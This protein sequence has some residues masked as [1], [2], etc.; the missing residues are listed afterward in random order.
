[1]TI[2][3]RKIKKK[4]RK[5]KALKKY[6]PEHFLNRELSWLEFNSRVLNE[7]KT[8]STPLLER[9]RFLSIYT[10][11][12]DE[13]VMKRVG[14]LKAHLDS[15]YKSY[16]LDGLFPD[17]QLE[18]IREKIL[19]DNEQLEKTFKEIKNELKKHEI[20]LSHWSDLTTK[21][22]EYCHQYFEKELYPI[23]TPLSVDSGRPFPF[24]SNLSYSFG[25]II[26]NPMSKEKKFSRVKVPEGS[27]EWIEIPASSKNKRKFINT[28]EIIENNLSKLYHGMSIINVMPF[29]ITRNADWEHDDEDTE[30]LL[31]LIEESVNIR[32]LQEP[33]RI[34]CLKNHDKG[35]LEYLM[36][37]MGLTESELYMYSENLDY[38]SLASLC[39][40]KLPELKNKEWR[41][42]TPPYFSDLDMFEVIDKEDRL[43]HHPYENFKTS[44][45]RFI[46]DASRDSDVLSIKMTLYRTEDNSPFIQ[47]L[48]NAAENGIQVVCLIELKARFDEKR[49]IQWARKMEQAG[50]HVVYGI[51][52]LKTHSKIAM[53][54]RRDKSGEL[55]RY[56]HIGTGN[57]NSKTARLYT[58]L[59]LFTT[60]QKITSE[61]NEVFNYLTGT[62]LMLDYEHLLVSPV[63]AKS[64]FLKKIQQQEQRAKNGKKGYIF[65][66]MNSLEDPVIIEALYKASKEGVKVDL[67]VRGFC[68]LKP[69]LKGLSENISV[70]SV[71]GR[72]LEHSRIYYFSDGNEEWSGEFFIGSADWMH[73]NLHSRV[74]VMVPIY[75]RKIKKDLSKFIEILLSDKYKSWKMKSDGTY[76][77]LKGDVTTCTHDK[78]M[79]LILRE[80]QKFGHQKL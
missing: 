45:E 12:L 51:V 19:I 71:V 1:M 55:L 20:F 37:E 31:G 62:S 63:N 80:H 57:Y 38:L 44:V 74:E 29:R 35:M 17:Q 5:L 13:F 72:F 78:M 9:V 2:I 64:K 8:V 53:V 39:N 6:I 68:C 3:K 70:Y 79:Q 66:K 43:V 24:I 23:L 52:G 67:I 73:R 15:S 41:P 42:L 61:I 47:A 32:R 30:D 22:K 76:E 49:N 69:A 34:E 25:L 58:D 7:A 60:D 48:I 65:A 11:N 46:I 10:S 27:H 28:S 18:L 56:V 77:Q 36:K 33:I 26:Q 4:K 14:G 50:V 16:S 75:S 21:E 54:V 59:G 40:L